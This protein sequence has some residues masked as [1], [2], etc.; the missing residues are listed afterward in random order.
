MAGY[1]HWMLLSDVLKDT[2]AETVKGVAFDIATTA[3]TL[4]PVDTGFLVNSIYVNAYDVSTYADATGVSS[5]LLPECDN[6]PDEFT[7][8]VAVGAEY[9]E[10]VEYGTRFMAAQPFFY[11]AVDFGRADFDYKLFMID[12]ELQGSIS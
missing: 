2:I 11:P 4:A 10:Y 3:R 1:N 6:P 12:S 5:K 7:A 9:G 8:Y